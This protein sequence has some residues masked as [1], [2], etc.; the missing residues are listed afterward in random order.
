MDTVREGEN[1]MIWGKS[2]ET[3]TLPNVKQTASGSLMYHTGNPRPVHC[4]N[5]WDREGGEGEFKRERTYVYLMLIDV[6]V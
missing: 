5:R 3:H 4:D 2:I 1:G 6:D